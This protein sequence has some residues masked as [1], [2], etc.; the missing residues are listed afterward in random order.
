MKITKGTAIYTG[1]GFYTVIG[2][3]EDGHWFVGFNEFCAVINFDPRT[4]D[5][6]MDDLKI[7]YCDFTEE[8]GYVIPVDIKEKYEAYLDFCKR[9]ENQE[10]GI[11]DGYE[12]FSN[13]DYDIISYIDFSYFEELDGGVGEYDYNAPDDEED[14]END[15]EVWYLVS[16]EW[17]SY[18]LTILDKDVDRACKKLWKEFKKSCHKNGIIDDTGANTWEKLR[19]DYMTIH[20]LTPGK[21]EWL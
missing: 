1:G 5:E 17:R 13:H 8:E 11:E 6:E 15:E 4:K 21:V 18:T 16:I 12:D 14:E 3:T 10:S 19:D 2:E 7:F 20:E 9:L